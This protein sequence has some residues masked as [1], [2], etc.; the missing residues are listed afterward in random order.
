M[1]SICLQKATI[2]AYM[3]EEHFHVCDDI[4]CIHIAVNDSEA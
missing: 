2:D 1:T 4:S 3:G